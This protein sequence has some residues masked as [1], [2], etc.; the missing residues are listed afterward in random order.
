MRVDGHY[1]EVYGTYPIQIIVDSI[2]I[3]RKAYVTSASDQVGAINIGQE[4]LKVRQIG[5]N[6]MLERNAVYIGCEADVASHV[7]DVQGR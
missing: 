5:Q 4:E 7:L 1:I 6:T 3:Y 2:N